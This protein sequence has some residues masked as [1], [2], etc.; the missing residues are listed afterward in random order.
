MVLDILHYYNSKY[1]TTIIMTSSELEEL[2]L[3]CDRIAIVDEGQ[4]SGI[5]PPTAKSAEF[6]LL[7]LG[8]KS[9]AKEVL[10]GEGKG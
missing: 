9:E 6:G 7:M 5:L 8:K 2:R 3:T 10:T 4:I 1:G